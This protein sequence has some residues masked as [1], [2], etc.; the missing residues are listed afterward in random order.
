MMAESWL[1]LVDRSDVPLW[2]KLRFSRGPDN[3][4]NQ[5]HMES[6]DVQDSIYM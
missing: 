6:D 3:Y 5:T 2:S 4:M 1:D